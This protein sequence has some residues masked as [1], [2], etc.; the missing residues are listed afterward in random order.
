MAAARKCEQFIENLVCASFVVS[1]AAAPG[2]SFRRSL[3]PSPLQ[4]VPFTPRT[5]VKPVCSHCHS[6]ALLSSLAFCSLDAQR[7]FKAS[8]QQKRAIA[9]IVGANHEIQRVLLMETFCGLHFLRTPLTPGALG[10]VTVDKFIRETMIFLH[11]EEEFWHDRQSNK[12]VYLP[13]MRPRVL[14]TLVMRQENWN[15]CANE[16]VAKGMIQTAMVNL[17]F[18]MLFFLE[19]PDIELC[20]G[21]FFESHHG[22]T[23]LCGSRIVRFISWNITVPNLATN[24]ENARRCF[25]QALFNYV[26]RQMLCLYRQQLAFLLG[27][28]QCPLKRQSSSFGKRYRRL[29][30]NELDFMRAQWTGF[31]N[32]VHFTIQAR[33]LNTTLCE[34]ALYAPAP[35]DGE[36]MK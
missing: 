20:K 19:S 2:G 10:N 8:E 12:L 22:R 34:L 25:L 11:N 15:T 36:T 1:T 27:E 24:E 33:Q 29:K 3:L 18:S 7:Y 4:C 32:L 31:T 35:A 21:L 17:S 13:E 14:E 5:S 28:W 16:F 26:T 30:E 6:P 23:A 9:R